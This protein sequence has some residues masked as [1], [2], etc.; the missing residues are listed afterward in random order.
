MH[1]HGSNHSLLLLLEHPTSIPFFSWCEENRKDSSI[2]KGELLF[3]LESHKNVSNA[4]WKVKNICNGP[5]HLDNWWQEFICDSCDFDSDNKY[6][7]NEWISTRYEG[8]ETL[9][10]VVSSNSPFG[11]KRFHKFVVHI[12]SGVVDKIVQS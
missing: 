4:P 10:T 12:I 11:L 2:T 7:L 9:S 6:S 1:A 5:P 3:S 8:F